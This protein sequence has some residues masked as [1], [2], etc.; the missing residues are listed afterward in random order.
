MKKLL[1]AALTL[2]AACGQ[3]GGADT[4]GA[5]SGAGSR[6]PA[7]ASPEERARR[8]AIYTQALAPLM[9]GAYGGNC[10]KLAGAAP[11]AGV[12]ISAA[13]DISAEG[14]SRNL[15][16]A[17]DTLLLARTM[18]GGVADSAMILA[19]SNT[20]KWTLGINDDGVQRSAMFGDGEAVT[21]CQQVPQL[22]LLRAKSIYPSIAAIFAAGGTTLPCLVDLTST[23]DLAVSA[24]P[25]GVTVD[26]KLISLARD[27]K[28]ESAAVDAGTMTLSYNAEFTDGT[29]LSIS[30]DD[31]GK[32]SDVSSSSHGKAAFMC[33]KAQS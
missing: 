16:V 32:L 24:G 11:A 20:P 2:L 30:V 23:R 21:S 28:K 7:I 25:D 22:S 9:A 19:T 14:F 1:I 27:M 8:I 26:G 31:S 3:R 17:D 33:S 6:T 10:M 29:Q 12:K 5:Q 18:R 15:A 4:A 13:G